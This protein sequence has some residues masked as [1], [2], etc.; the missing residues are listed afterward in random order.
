VKWILKQAVRDRLPREILR[1]KKRGFPTPLA[2]MLQND[3][4]EYLHDILL[5]SQCLDRLYFQRQTVAR[6]VHEHCHRQ[7]DHHTLLWKLIVLEEWHRQFIDGNNT[8]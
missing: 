2:T 4:T 3:F 8:F 1:R 7:R 6:I 5:S